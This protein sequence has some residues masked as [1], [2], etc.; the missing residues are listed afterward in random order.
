MAISDNM[1]K[2]RHKKGMTQKQVAE[3]CGL[4]G[5]TIRTY[6]LGNANPKPATVAKIA[7]ALGVSAA[8]LYGVDWMP[9][10]S[11]T[12]DLET[13]SALYQSLL[14]GG[15]DGTLPIDTPN[16]ARLL[17]AFGRLNEAGQ[18]EA[19]KR[20]E[21]LAQV[22][23]YQTSAGGFTAEELESIINSCRRIHNSQYELELMEQQGVTSGGAVRSSKQLIADAKEEIVEIVLEYFTRQ[24]IP[25]KNAALLRELKQ[26]AAK[27]FNTVKI[28]SI[29]GQEPN[30]VPINIP[31]IDIVL[32][33]EGDDTCKWYFKCPSEQAN[34]EDFIP[35]DVFGD[36]VALAE[37]HSC[38]VS[39]VLTSE[40]EFNRMRKYYSQQEIEC[41]ALAA[42][43]Q[44]KRLPT[45][46]SVLL[47][48]TK[49][50]KIADEV[51]F[52]DDYDDI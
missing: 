31:Y 48:D 41:E 20:T 38:R 25:E 52:E 35:S 7:K 47:F 18:L 34:Q 16:K 4:A 5:S 23:A 40:D 45:H 10:I 9:G 44:S 27:I 49:A 15:S 11:A 42:L 36:A 17:V 29:N 14:S 13:N 24:S 39:I 46:I 33:D 30:T 6:E 37:Q 50:K 51:F 26:H 21:E 2:I 28:S 43:N 1:R 12:P 8:E 3:A 32:M 19:I 22:P